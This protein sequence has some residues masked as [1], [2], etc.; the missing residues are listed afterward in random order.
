MPLART[1]KVT[2]G[3]DG[4]ID[5]I[6]RVRY[7]KNLCFETLADFGDYVQRRAHRSGSLELA[8]ITQK[9]GGNMPIFSQA[10][11]KLGTEVTCIGAMGYPDVL[12]LFEGLG[13]NCRLKSVSEPGQCLALE[14][15]DGKLM[16]ANNEGI[17]ELT[18]R[19]LLD[20]AGPEYLLDTFMHS[21][22]IVMLNWSELRESLSIW[23]GLKSDIFDRLDGRP[24]EMFIDLSDCTSRTPEDILE[25]VRL[26]KAFSGRFSVSVSLNRNEAERVAGVN[27][28]KYGSMEELVG[29]LHRLLACKRLVIHLVDCCYCGFENTVLMQKNRY[30]EHPVLS[31]GGG[32]NFNAG[33]VY[34]ILCELDCEACVRLANSVSGYYVAHGCSPSPEELEQWLDQ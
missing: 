26:I 33:F 30:I 6:C 4:Y 21:D 34:G 5:T 11:A 9:I 23:H 28:V 15:D 27:G 1:K 17:E 2:A 14:F 31:T 20:C 29:G 18:Y 19:R 22:M 32:D 3:F 7:G 8:R 13:P 25:A 16:L 10:L 12:P 24:R